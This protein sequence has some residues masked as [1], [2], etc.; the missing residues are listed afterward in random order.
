VFQEIADWME[1]AGENVFKIRAYR[2]AAEAV[3]V[4]PEPIE[5]ASETGALEQIEGLGAATVA[6][7]REFL[8]TGRVQELEKLRAAY[9]PGCWN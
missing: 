5:D 8:A 1:V 2:R 9:P 4:Y 3:A 6:K 7:T